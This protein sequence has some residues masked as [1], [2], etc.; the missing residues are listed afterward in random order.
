MHRDRDQVRRQRSDELIAVL[1]LAQHAGL[2]HRAGDGLDK[3]RNA[4]GPRHD[5]LEDFIGERP[6]AGHAGDERPGRSF[7]QRGDRDLAVVRR[8]R[9][10]DG[11]FRAG[12]AHQQQRRGV[13][14]GN[15]HLQQVQRGWIGPVQVF[16]QH[17]HRRPVGAVQEQLGED[18][19]RALA[20]PDRRQVARRI[21]PVERNRQ[22]GSEERHGLVRPHAAKRDEL[23]EPPQDGGGRRVI[24]DAKA[25][26]EHLGHGMERAVHLVGRALGL[27]DL[28]GPAPCRP[29]GGSQ[30][31]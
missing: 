28:M 24:L 25:A 9:P 16:D 23:L 18:L 11:P 17:Q 10:G 22:Q 13:L 29:S 19:E 31:T 6:A 21:M 30:Q 14:P 26:T 7:G 3:K 4:A 8:G 27:E 20:A 1:E 12:G 2:E 15:Q 5:L